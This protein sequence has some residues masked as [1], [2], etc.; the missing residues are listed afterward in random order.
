MA[1]TKRNAG[2]TSVLPRATLNDEELVRCSHLFRSSSF[3]VGRGARESLNIRKELISMSFVSPPPC[4]KCTCTRKRCR[5][6]SIQYRARLRT[7]SSRGRLLPRPTAT[8]ARA[9]SGASH[10]KASA[11][12]NVA[13][14]ATRSA[15][16]CSMPIA[17]KVS[18]VR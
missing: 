3:G 1:A 14:S 2:L 17:Y 13:S 7:I 4:R 15:R 6:S 12:L 9:S 8:S 11:A 10:A 18:T 5:V 16:I